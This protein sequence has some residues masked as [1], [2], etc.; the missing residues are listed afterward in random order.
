VATLANLSA[1]SVPQV[2][3]SVLLV[4]GSGRLSDHNQ[5]VARPVAPEP[6]R[7]GVVPAPS[8]RNLWLRAR[9]HL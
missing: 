5:R 8:A 6:H 1:L 2:T 3:R 9:L 7:P 4:T